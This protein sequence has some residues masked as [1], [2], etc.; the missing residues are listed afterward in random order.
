[1]TIFKQK[2]NL[3]FSYFGCTVLLHEFGTKLSEI[4]SAP[5]Y[6][7]GLSGIISVRRFLSVVTV[8]VC[9]SNLQLHGASDGLMVLGVAL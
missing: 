5:F 1:M 2:S 6:L 8:S 7:C 3:T 9:L 4:D